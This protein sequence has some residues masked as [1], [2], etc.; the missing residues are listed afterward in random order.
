MNIKNLSIKEKLILLIAVF[1]VSSS[2]IGLASYR[3]IVYLNNLNDLANKTEKIKILALELRKNEK[4]FLIREKTNPVFFKSGN[5]KYLSAHNSNYDNLQTL[6]NNLSSSGLI[7]N[8]TLNN[9]I[10]QISISSVNYKKNFEK[11]VE[12]YKYRGFKNFGKTGEMREK[13]H[14]IENIIEKNNYPPALLNYILMMRRHEKDY[15]LRNDPGYQEKLQQEVNSSF[16]YIDRNNLTS[17]AAL[18]QGIKEYKKAFD[19]IVAADEKIG[20]D[21]KSG[22]RG[23]TESINT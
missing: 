9:E 14:T 6:L 17:A 19:S 1:I 23:E 7:S 16:I 10:K 20:R 13:I 8:F 21:E 2:I 3:K 4:D 5:S 22:A 12:N 11:L 18:K 15:L